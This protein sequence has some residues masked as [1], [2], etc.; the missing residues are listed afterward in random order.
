[1]PRVITQ[2]C[3]GV[4]DAACTQVCPVDAIHPR[5]D[6][7]DYANVDQLFI[8]PNDCIDCGACESVCPVNAI[9]P[10]EDV[11]EDLKSFIEKNANYYKK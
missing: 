7:A 5:P 3:I 9:Y 6:E 10:L 8:N 1:M 4:K 2:A 11:P